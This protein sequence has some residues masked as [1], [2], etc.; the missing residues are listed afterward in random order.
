MP[1][2]DM[3][4]GLDHGEHRETECQRNVDETDTKLGE[5]G[6]EDGGSGAAEDEPEG[7]EKLCPRR[8]DIGI[9]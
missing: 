6:R 5:G 7:S 2:R 1:T 3:P 9:G 4:D 8:L